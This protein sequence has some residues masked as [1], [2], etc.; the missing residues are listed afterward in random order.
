MHRFTGSAAALLIA[1]SCFTGSLN[2]NANR[3]TT[4]SAI[5]PTDTTLAALSA[6]PTIPTTDFVGAADYLSS[7]SVQGVYTWE[8][9]K[10]P[11]KVFIKADPS[12]HGYRPQFAGM[13]R[14]AFDTWSQA[15]GGKLSWREVKNASDADVNIHWTTVVTERPNGTEAGETNAYTQLNRA[16]NRG[17][18]YGAKMTLLT[19]L[20]GQPFG[21]DFMNKTIIHETGHALGLQ[22]H[23]PNRT[24]IMFYAINNDQQPMLTSRDTAT[25]KHLYADF[26]SSDNVALKAK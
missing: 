23:S 17:I 11:I 18:I 10:L 19:E 24:D 6:P 14:N 26:G 22:G 3:T 25:M 4:L 13:V 1:L 8:A 16:T 5:A 2:N 9:D 7:V 12:V 20:N 15:S 21:D